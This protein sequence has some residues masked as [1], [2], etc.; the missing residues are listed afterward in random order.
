MPAD[1]DAPPGTDLWAGERPRSGQPLS[2]PADGPPFVISLSDTLFDA[3]GA[4]TQ[5]D[6]VRPAE[7]WSRTDELRQIL[8]GA[9]VA[10][11]VLEHLAGPARR[12]AV[13]GRRL[14]CWWAL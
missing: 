10:A 3:L 9:E 5:D 1:A 11:D 14:Y 12:A 7:P 8:I 2:L 4:A 6:L 13:S